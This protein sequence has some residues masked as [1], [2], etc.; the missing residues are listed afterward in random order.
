MEAAQQNEVVG[1][2][3]PAPPP[4]DEVVRLAPG[5]RPPAPA[6]GATARLLGLEFAAQARPRQAPV[7]PD[8]HRLAGG[9]VEHDGDDPGLAGQQ[10][11][12]GDRDRSALQ[13]RDPPG[14]LAPEGG[15]VGGQVE[16]RGVA[17]AGRGGRTGPVDGDHLVQCLGPAVG[18]R[19]EHPVLVGLVLAGWGDGGFE[20]F[21]EQPPGVGG[22]HSVDRP[23]AVVLFDQIES[24]EGLLGQS[25]EEGLAVVEGGLEFV[26]VAVEV[27][28]GRV[29]AVLGDQV[30][31]GRAGSLGVEGGGDGFG[32]GGLGVEAE[33]ADAFEAAD[34]GRDRADAGCS[35]AGGFGE[36]GEF[37]GGAGDGGQFGGAGRSEVEG[38]HEP[39]A[40]AGE[41][42][43]V[44]VDAPGLGLDDL[45]Q[46]LGVEG[47]D[48]GGG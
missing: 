15:E 8:L 28:D 1:G 24:L 36:V 33:G 30:L 3:R 27:A 2:G 25:V 40:E 22:H 26:E 16:G 9:V 12:L 48:R 21:G 7:G 35:G 44:A 20:V 14:V 23:H 13:Q 31:G 41:A 38:V 17:V 29:Y 6:P 47:V 42:A 46:G 19:R 18:R 34:G 32:V 39:V 37:A 4:F 5:D 10:A 45:V 11:R 43:E